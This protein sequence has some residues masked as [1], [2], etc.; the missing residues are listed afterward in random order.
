VFLLA[1]PGAQPGASLAPGP[2]TLVHPDGELHVGDRLSFEVIAPE[3]LD[4][5]GRRVHVWAGLPAGPSLASEAFNGYGIAG[6]QQATL[7]WA[8]DTSQAEPG[9]HPLTFAILPQGPVWV[10]W[11]HLLPPAMTPA[12]APATWR[13]ASS[14]CCTVHYITGTP[15]E[16][17]LE[18]LLKMVDAQ[19]VQASR[20]LDTRFEEPV[21]L[22]LLGR[23]LGHGGFAGGE[24]SISYLERNYAGG[25]LEMIL[26]HEMVHIL[27]SRLGGE[28]RPPLLVE[29][30]AV[31]LTGGHYKPEPLMPR[32]AALL[33]LD[34]YQPLAALADR[35]YPYQHEAGYIQAGALVQ[36]MV[37][38]WG[39][40][41]FNAFYRDIQPA[42]QGGLSAA[43]DRAL[44]L[45]L[46]I[47]LDELDASLRETLR[48]QPPS[49]GER[50]DVRLTVARYDTL[51]RYQQALDP[52]AYYLTAWLPDGNAM[53]TQQITAD[54]LRGPA[55]PANVILELLLMAA[56]DRLQDGDPAAAS[57]LLESINAA[58]DELERS[59][60]RWPSAR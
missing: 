53:R 30:L 35:F 18:A 2:V 42:P 59:Q 56:G 32:A 38:R 22:T 12:S 19:A 24:I 34:L 55:A 46:E 25:D 33:E 3:G 13:R 28:L 15:A 16:R 27:D 17:D 39:W 31:Y 26:R 43:I 9:Y 23:V 29:G 52:S 60:E 11:V 49:P 50:E 7:S 51:R 48:S 41:A 37:E 44:R 6:R 20:L 1:H 10:E 58:L 54:V 4:P 40:K 36:Y 45:H 14:V 5:Q 8:W 57:R 47:G 21:E